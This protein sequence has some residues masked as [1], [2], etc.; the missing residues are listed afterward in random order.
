MASVPTTSWKIGE[1]VETMTDCIFLSS[2]I[3]VNGNCTHEVKTLTIERKTMTKT[4]SVLKNKDVTLPTEVH[5]V[6][7]MVFPVVIYGCKS[8][9][10]KKPQCQRID[11]FK[12]WCSRR[13][14]RISWTARRSNQSILKEIILEYSLKRLMLTL[15]LQYFGH[16][17]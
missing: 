4:D 14:L 5:I 17:M 3:T 12:L 10:I 16:L 13:L 2:K 9:T 8:W 15:K 1:K 6:K 11:Y 7:A